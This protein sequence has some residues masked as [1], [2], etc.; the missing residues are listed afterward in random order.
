M[1]GEIP[2]AK[3]TNDLR[4]AEEGEDESTLSGSE[5]NSCCVGGEV[6]GGEEVAE[7]LGYVAGAVD[8]EERFPQSFPICL[9]C[10]SALARR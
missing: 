5:P 9:P 10:C 6:E 1:I 7:S 8:P 3:L 4:D 2:E